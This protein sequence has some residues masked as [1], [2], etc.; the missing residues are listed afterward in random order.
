MRNILLAY[1][2]RDMSK[3][4]LLLHLNLLLKQISRLILKTNSVCLEIWLLNIKL[5]TETVLLGEEMRLQL[6]VNLIHLLLMLWISSMILYL[7]FLKELLIL[8]LL[9]LCY[10]RGLLLKFLNTLDN[11]NPM[12]SDIDPKITLEILVVNVIHQRA[13]YA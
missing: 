3:G 7:Q 10:L 6:R 11:F 5:H 1:M 13:I 8:L 12:Q 4:V 2:I 9:Y